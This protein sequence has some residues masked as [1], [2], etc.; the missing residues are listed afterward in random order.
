MVW[1]GNCQ[2]VIS[3]TC[4]PLRQG[5]GFVDPSKHNSSPTTPDPPCNVNS[6]IMQSQPKS[7]SLIMHICDWWNKICSAYSH[8]WSICADLFS[9]NSLSIN[10]ATSFCTYTSRSSWPLKAKYQN[11]TEHTAIDPIYLRNRFHFKMQFRIKQKFFVT[12][13]SPMIPAWESLAVI[14]LLQSTSNVQV[15]YS[16]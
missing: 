5:P 14:S 10:L 15:Q 8:A 9:R 16:I 3:A 2:F 13:T 12:F 4:L 1:L 11:I 7:Q 6:G